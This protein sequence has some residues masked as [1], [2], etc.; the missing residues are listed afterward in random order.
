MIILLLGL[1]LQLMAQQS[2]QPSTT[3]PAPPR[4]PFRMGPVIVSP[5]ILPD[6]RVT[7]RLYAPKATTVTI[8]G[9]WMEGLERQ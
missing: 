6:N 1:S 3:V 2:G 7:F 4:V 5:E 8:S 9:D